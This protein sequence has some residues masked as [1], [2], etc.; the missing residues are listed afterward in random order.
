MLWDV[1]GWCVCVCVCCVVLCVCGVVLCLWC[2]CVCV[3]SCVVCWC[4]W[5]VGG[6]SNQGDG[7]AIEW[8]LRSRSEYPPRARQRGPAQRVH[9]RE[10]TPSSGPGQV[11]WCLPGMAEG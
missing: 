2:V 1:V 5:C 8:R 10:S 3:M 6:V 9:L 7:S 11:C 4:V